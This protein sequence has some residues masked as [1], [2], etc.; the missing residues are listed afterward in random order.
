MSAKLES[1]FECV[2]QHVVQLSY[3]WKIFCQL[4][5]SGSEN[6]SLLNASGGN[7]FN[8]F[9]CLIL[10]DAILALSRFTD[11]ASSG[12]NRNNAN[13]RHLFKLSE[14]SLNSDVIVE[15]N[16]ALERLD[17]HMQ[18]LRAYRN[19]ALAHADLQHSLQEAV[20]SRITYDELEGA[21]EECR[22]I[23]RKLRENLFKRTPRYDVIIPYGRSGS[24]LLKHLW[25]AHAKTITKMNNPF[26]E[27]AH[28]AGQ[29]RVL[30]YGRKTHHSCQTLNDLYRKFR[31]S[32]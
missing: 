3:R 9:Q 13:I 31:Q 7:V 2:N 5:D 25:K 19:K 24:D 17:A 30:C 12:K 6:I 14:G 23:M 27:S 8:L 15:I 29:P 28:N 32:I 16:A 4:F 11:P 18:S 22:N 20:P 21:M 26:I 1:V 10:D